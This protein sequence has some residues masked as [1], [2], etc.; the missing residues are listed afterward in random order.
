MS[1]QPLQI[2]P[3]PVEKDVARGDDIGRLLLRSLK[4]NRVSL[5]NHDVLVVTQK[6]ISKS[7]GRILDL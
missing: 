4:A 5:K 1:F 6:I 7:E 2:I 3:I